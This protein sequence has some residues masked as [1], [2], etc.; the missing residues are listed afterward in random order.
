[1]DKNVKSIADHNARL[2]NIFSVCQGL[3]FVLPVLLLYYRDK[4]GLGFQELM[5][6]EAVFSTVI[7]TCEVPTGWLADHWKR[8]YV[9]ALAGV[10]GM[11][12]YTLLLTAHSFVAT[13]V[14]QGAIGV[15]V[16]LVSGTLSAIH[17]DSLL[18]E[19]RVDEYRRQEG[20]R[21]GL[22]LLSVGFS[23]LL[24]GFL[25]GINHDLPLI[26]TI[27]ADAG[28]VVTALL[29]REPVRV[30]STERR[31]PFV[32][33]A[34][35]MKYALHGHREVA[36]IIFS[37][38]ALFGTTK[39]LMWAQQPYYI[40]IH[41]DEKWFGVLL[42]LG[43]LAGSAASQLGHKLD[44]RFRSRT[45]LFG[46]TIAVI[47][48]C[49]LSAALHSLAGAVLLLAGSTFWGLGWPRV[50]DALNGCVD[51]GRRAMVLSTCSLMIHVV[52]VP[53]SLVVGKVSMLYGAEAAVL[54]L[55]VV[56]AF[57]AL[58]LLCMTIREARS[59]EAAAL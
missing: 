7:L 26:G 29:M 55:V 4:V 32:T 56:P 49:G 54:S 57:A 9:L 43:F 3:I 23:S 52:F 39:M 50:Q 14:A 6:G 11:I 34:Q 42:A 31:N 18:M 51:S 16:S 8:K 20:R 17:Y 2:L 46:M 27:L 48:I 37:A 53:L 59:R 21:H 25:Y 40:A 1:M 30:R 12:A 10:T 45:V 47:V 15:G 36:E 38:A 22:A 19:N 33:M 58:A 41:L 5:I 44:H 24:G 35:T 28:L 13:V